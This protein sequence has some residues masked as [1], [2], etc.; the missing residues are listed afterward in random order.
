MVLALEQMGFEIEASHHETAPGQH[1]IDL[2]KDTLGKHI[3]ERFMNAG[4][5][6]WDRYRSTVHAW[7]VSRHL[8]MY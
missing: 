4:I 8:K 6:E 1:E 2:I 7:E 3:Y 5:N